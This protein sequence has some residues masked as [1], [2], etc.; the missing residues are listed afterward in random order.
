MAVIALVGI[1]GCGSGRD[2]PKISP[3]AAPTA[4]PPPT[5]AA[6]QAPARPPHPGAIAMVEQP[7]GGERLKKASEVPDS[8]AWGLIDGKPV[9]VVRVVRR[10]QGVSETITRY[11][12]GLQFIDR[13]RRRREVPPM[14][15]P[16]P[17]KPEPSLPTAQ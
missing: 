5:P 10:R 9:P 13:T 17:K 16:S 7:G 2:D 11:G 12:P 4:A 6:T 14:P 15:A 1:W 3:D 8:V